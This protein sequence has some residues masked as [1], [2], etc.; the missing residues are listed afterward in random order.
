MMYIGPI[1]SDNPDSNSVESIIETGIKISSFYDQNEVLVCDVFEFE[2]VSEG[3]KYA[4][5]FYD[6]REP[7]DFTHLDS[8]ETFAE[9]STF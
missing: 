8:A 1:N 2:H 4:V 7:V 5:I 6:G 9:D 3:K